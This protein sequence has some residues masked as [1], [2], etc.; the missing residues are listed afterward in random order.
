MVK[1]TFSALFKF[2]NSRVALAIGLAGISSIALVEPALAH[3]PMGGALPANLFEGLM[4]G[5]AHPILGPDHFAFIVAVG[6]LAAVTNLGGLIPVAFVLLGLVGTG[7]HLAAV[8]L[9]MP[10]VFISA[11]VLGSGLMLALRQRPPLTVLLGLAAIA[12]LF[13][14][15]A[16]GEAIIGAEMTPLIAYLAGFT[17]IQLAISLAA[18]WLGRSLLK[19]ASQTGLTFRFAGFTIFGAGTAFLASTVLS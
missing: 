19:Q 5:L 15:Y 12:G 3:H 4:S 9:P 14:G 11:S 13:H 18:F 10:E 2:W 8:T 7:L 1:H 16:Y 17:L 6:L